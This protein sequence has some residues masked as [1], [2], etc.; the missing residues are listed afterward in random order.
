MVFVALAF[1]EPCFFGKVF[2]FLVAA[3][4]GPVGVGAMGFFEDLFR[5]GDDLGFSVLR[6]RVHL[7]RA[8]SVCRSV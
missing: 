2:V 8:S 1:D 7:N 4:E 5:F 6:W 3:G